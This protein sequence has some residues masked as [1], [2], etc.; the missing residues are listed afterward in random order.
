[1]DQSAFYPY[2]G[3]QAHD[4]GVLTIEGFDDPFKVNDVQKVGKVVLH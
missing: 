4:T 1:L 3:G 2:S